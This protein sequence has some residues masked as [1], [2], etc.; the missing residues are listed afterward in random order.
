MLGF[1]ELSLLFVLFIVQSNW[2]IGRG[3][4]DWRNI[5]R[6]ARNHERNLEHH[7]TFRTR[8]NYK[9][10]TNETVDAHQQNC[11]IY[12]VCNLKTGIFA[13]NLSLYFKSVSVFHSKYWASLAITFSHFSGSIWIPRRRSCSSI[14]AKK[15]SSQFWD[16]RLKW[17]V[18]QKVHSASIEKNGSQKAQGLV[19]QNFP[20]T[21]FQVLF[22]RF[23]D[24]R[25]SVV[26]VENFTLVPAR[27]FWAF[28]YCY[29]YCSLRTH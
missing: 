5:Q 16:P 24:V 23:C 10:T 12:C 17:Y 11:L 26:V 3:H 20:F 25:P 21:I 28:F 8:L 4:S 27:I 14:G 22:H 1:I 15:L 7:I 2:A 18:F 19:R 9:Q 13:W 6:A 29:C